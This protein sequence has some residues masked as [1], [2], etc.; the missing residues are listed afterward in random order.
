MES[1]DFDTENFSVSSLIERFRLIP[2]V[3]IKVNFLLPISNGTSIES[4]VVPDSE[5]TTNLSS[6]I[7]AFTR[8]DLPAFGLPI[9]EIFIE[10]SSFIESSVITSSS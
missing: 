8:V 1:T 7:K 9:I 6:P 3:S 10:L 4:R 2:A 5:E